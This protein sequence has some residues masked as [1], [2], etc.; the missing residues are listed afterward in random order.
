M[1]ACLRDQGT[2]RG[3]VGAA[4]AG[5]GAAVVD[6]VHAVDAAHEAFDGRC[7]WGA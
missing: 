1:P 7:S 2:A 6:S 3:Q 4:M 5:A